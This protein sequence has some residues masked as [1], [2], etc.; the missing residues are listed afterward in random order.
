[1]K[2]ILSF[3]FCV[4]LMGW[5]AAAAEWI[6]VEC[7][8]Y[9]PYD[10]GTITASGERVHEGGVACN[11]LPLGTQVEIDGIVYTVNDRSGVDGIID[12]FMN[13][14]DSAIEFGRRIKNVYVR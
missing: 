8:A 1:M 7:T 14:Y 9:T 13:D 3:I 11:F 5:Q 12:I 10:C 2:K 4:F 6:T